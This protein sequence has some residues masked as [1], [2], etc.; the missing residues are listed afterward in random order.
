MTSRIKI[1]YSLK[2]LNILKELSIKSKI[3]K[4]NFVKQSKPQLNPLPLYKL[5]IKTFDNC[6]YL[7]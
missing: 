7:N 6:V 2:S 4:E 3:G 5:K 1:K